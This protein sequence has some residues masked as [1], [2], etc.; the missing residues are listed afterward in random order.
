MRVTEIP[1]TENAAELFAAISDL[2]W[3]VFLDS[4]GLGRC[5]ILAAAPCVTFVNRDGLTSIED[6]RDKVVSGEDP[7]DLIRRRLLPY[8]SS[9][10]LPFAG[11]AI[12][13]F[14]YDLGLRLNAIALR[15]KQA[16]ALPELA[17]GIYDWT[18]IVDHEQKRAHL[19][20]N[21]RDPRTPEIWEDLLQRLSAQ[22]SA[23]RRDSFALTGKLETLPSHSEYAHAFEKIKAYIA[24][25]DCYQVNFAQRFSAP[26]SGDPWQLYLASRK[27]NPAPFSAYLSNPHCAVLSASPERFLKVEDGRVETKPIKGTRP[28][29]DDPAQDAQLALS[30]S[31]SAKDKAENLMIVDLLRND[32]GKICATGSVHVDNLFQ[33][34]S[35]ATVHHLVST[36]SGRIEPMHDALSLL[37]ASFPGGSITGAPK[38]RAMQIIEELEPFRRGLYCGAIARIGFD[39]NMD[40]SIAIRTMATVNSRISLWAGGGIVADSELDAE[41]QEIRDKAQA[42]LRLLESP[43]PSC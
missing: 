8:S 36:I 14:G 26:Y 40:S 13:Y 34:E 33:I 29:S 38:R 3:P 4:A 1:Y 24:S 28:R 16:S 27:A 37:K 12:G 19:A 23:A 32:L 30:L 31:H 43:H 41:Y 10:E 35:F 9:S 22:R 21:C 18:V 5:D 42:M 2:P 39:G 25:G 6:A 11:G 15:E 7:F 17:V 20:S